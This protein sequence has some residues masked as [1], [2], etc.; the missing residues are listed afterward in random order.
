MFLHD[1]HCKVGDGVKGLKATRLV[2]YRIVISN[3]NQLLQ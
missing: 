2:S 3:N 1:G